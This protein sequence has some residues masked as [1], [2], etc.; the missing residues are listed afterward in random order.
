MAV[1][2]SYPMGEGRRGEGLVERKEGKKRM[3]WGRSVSS[4]EREGLSIKKE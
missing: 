3:V 2:G 1:T 4:C